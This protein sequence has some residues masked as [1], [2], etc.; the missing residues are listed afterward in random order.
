[1]VILSKQTFR[2][3][4]PSP[5]SEY[6]ATTTARS[7]TREKADQTFSYSTFSSPSLSSSL[8]SFFPSRKICADPRN[9]SSISLC[10]NNEE[11][12]RRLSPNPFPTFPKHPDREKRSG[13]GLDSPMKNTGAEDEDEDEEE[14]IGRR[15]RGA[16]F[17][18]LEGRCFA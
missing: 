6:I 11:T 2:F 5:Y 3:K 12:I 14:E 7:K 17:R 4:S 10:S 8:L 13:R 15:R 18:L 9:P 1:M 16:F